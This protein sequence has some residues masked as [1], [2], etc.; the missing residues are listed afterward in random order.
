M[1]RFK[2]RLAR[3][4]AGRYG[5]DQLYNA[6][7]VVAFIGIIVNVFI[8][9]SIL[10]ILI[11][12]LFIGAIFRSMSRDIIQRSRENQK[13]MRLWTPVKSEGLLT[14]RRIKEVKTRRFRRCPYCRTVLRLPRKTGRNSVTCPACHNKFEVQILI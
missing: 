1:E 2:E 12:A 3:F 11:L 6:L 13:F 8:Q 10:N 14:R 9:S 4:M 7:L 5:V